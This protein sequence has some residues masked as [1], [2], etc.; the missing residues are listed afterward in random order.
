MVI[1]WTHSNLCL[2][3]ALCL[4]EYNVAIEEKVENAN[5]YHRNNPLS[6]LRQVLP[7]VEIVKNILY[8]LQGQNYDRLHLLK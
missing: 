2:C 3:A 1:A 5:K 7:S 4:Y 6:S 8:I